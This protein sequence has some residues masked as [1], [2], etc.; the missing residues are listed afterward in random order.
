MTN[1]FREKLNNPLLISII[2]LLVIIFF[3]LLPIIKTYGRLNIMHDTL[4]PLIPQNSLNMLYQWTDSANGVYISNNL[5]VW[6]G[7]FYGLIKLGLS[8]YQAAFI[9]QFL[10]YLLSGLG[11]YMLYN[12]FNIGNKLFALIPAVFIILSPHYLDHMIYYQGTVGIIW[13]FYYI[14]KFIK[15]KKLFF[16]DIVFLALSVGIITD[17]PNPKYHGFVFLVAITAIIFSLITKALTLKNLF[18]NKL[19]LILF[20]LS[21]FYLSLPYL[22]YSYSFLKD[23]GIKISVKIGYK[24]TGVALDYGFA[25][26]SK[27]IQ[28][29]H[30]PNLNAKDYELISNV[31]FGLAYYLIPIVV[32]GIFPF[33]FRFL[34]KQSKKI[35]I[36]FYILILF[37]L[38]VSKGSNPPFGFIYDYLITNF[39]ALAFMR[40]TAGIVIFVAIFYALIYGRIF[41]FTAYI[42]L[43]KLKII[44][45]FLLGSLLMIVGYP[46][47]S[48]LFFLNRSTVNPYVNR[49][50]Y[51]LKVPVDYFRSA[52]F[53]KNIELDS[54]IDIYPY[55]LGYQNNKW[56]YFGFLIYPWVIDKPMISFDKRTD[57]DK[58]H[59]QTNALYIYHDKSLEDNYLPKLFFH[60]PERLL[61]SSPKV[62]IY[63]KKDIDFL[64]H[65]YNKELKEPDD[66]VIEFKKINPTKYRVVIHHTSN[67]FLL[68]FTE[69]FHPLWKIY[70]KNYNSDQNIN[71][72]N[73]QLDSNYK[74]PL[75][76]EDYRANKTEIS[77]Y[78]SRGELTTLGD[79][80]LKK[81]TYYK[82]QDEKIVPSNSENFYIDFISKNIKGT[83]QNNNL[84]RGNFYE[85]F[86]AKELKLPHRIV[87]DYANSWVINPRNICASNKSAC[88]ENADGSYDFEMI[89]EFW[90]QKLANASYVISSVTMIMIFLYYTIARSF[91]ILR[92][93]N[94]EV[95]N[96]KA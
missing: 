65:F 9:Y 78:L 4:V 57:V 58:T 63:K 25:L 33:I 49:K 68:T 47:W 80:K 11:I 38:F 70:L 88:Q 39:Q 93:R 12:L 15:Q 40:T 20:I 44:L 84:T 59:S 77:K 18:S 37:L 55:T 2:S 36:I 75:I 73:N 82:Y 94:N 67:S 29:F 19:N 16:Y 48:G 30:T 87:N 85:T 51:G 66:N 26:I 54:K 1:F 74:E 72:L 3:S 35:Y 32:L 76:S 90:P 81:K 13:S 21:S 91:A 69:N 23:S 34:D 79:M 95:S 41:Q 42:N 61:F 10:I 96:P 7:F 52:S 22:F 92:G 60:K 46:F 89:V 50:E 45:L 83:I 5:Y 64:P 31:Y 24:E 27:M 28:L 56:G 17:L 6:V 8:I 43:K 71:I 53:M 86:L 62:D 14:F